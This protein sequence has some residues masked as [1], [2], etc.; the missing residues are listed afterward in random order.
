MKRWIFNIVAGLSL[1]LCIAAAMVWSRSYSVG[2]LWQWSDPGAGRLLSL[3]TIPGTICVRW[4]PL[5][6]PFPAGYR[7][8]T[9][10][11]MS[12]GSPPP[13]FRFYGKDA[14]A[15]VAGW[16][17]TSILAVLPACWFGVLLLR[18]VRNSRRSNAP[19]CLNCGYNLTGNVSG[20]CP[21]CGMAIEAVKP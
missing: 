19:V 18:L 16:L 9:R 11:K 8:I 4:R 17:A 12:W 2:D 7:H 10:E 3:W 15:M 5:S 14:T 13:A 1:L 6:T 21:E 20:V